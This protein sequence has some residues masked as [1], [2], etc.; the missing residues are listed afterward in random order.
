[1]TATAI[2]VIL[3]TADGAT[4]L[5]AEWQRTLRALGREWQLLIPTPD[6]AGFGATIRAALP[7]VQHPLVLLTAADYP[8]TPSDIVAFLE[9]IEIP[10][11]MP[12]PATDEW[13]MKLPDLVIGVRTGVPVPRFLRFTGWLFR[14]FCRAVLATPVQP[15]P[16]WYGF[17]EHVKTWRAMFV[18]GVR[19]HDPHAAFKLIRR[20]LLE[21]FPIQCSGD[22]VHVELLGKAT[23]LTCMMDELPLTAK[24]DAVPASHWDRADQRKLFRRPKFWQA[25]TLETHG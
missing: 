16:G 20:S 7:H 4:P 8:Y 12:D 10:S 18:Y 3:P 14:A 13:R 11:E 23:F 24:P 22:L 5:V 25:K 2:T 6:P 15:L 1:M 17:W 19:A 21:R 9:R